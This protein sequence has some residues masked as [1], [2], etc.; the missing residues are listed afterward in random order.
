MVRLRWWMHDPHNLNNQDDQL[1]NLMGHMVEQVPTHLSLPRGGTASL[2]LPQQALQSTP[3]HASLSASHYV[4][5]SPNNISSVRQTDPVAA[6][7]T[8]LATQVQAASR[9][10]KLPPLDDATEGSG[11]ATESSERGIVSSNKNS[12]SSGSSL[13]NTQETN[14]LEFQHYAL[15]QSLGGNYAA[16]ISEP[17]RILDIGAGTGRW[18][19]EMATVFPRASVIGLDT[20][21]PPLASRPQNFIA[22]RGNVEENLP[23]ADGSFD[24]VHQRLVFSRMAVRRLH[25]GVAELVRVTAPGGWV[26]LVEVDVNICNGGMAN[27][28]IVTWATEVCRA[29]GIDPHMGTRV[30]D[31][32]RM[33]KL[34]NLD[35]RSIELP[36]GRWGG[37][38]GRLMAADMLAQ[39]QGMK[40]RICMQRRVKERE[41]EQVIWQMQQ[42]WEQKH[43]TM[44]F[45]V[46]YGQRDGQHTRR[47]KQA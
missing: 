7:A 38:I 12:V 2:A 1:E 13:W 16:P 8:T 36:I 29:S 40:E 47:A 34:Q 9:T 21:L 32:L 18:C 4:R 31:F 41:Y 22:M 10:A 37:R 17:R 28:K 23:F 20:M 19:I 46:A 42:E 24:F 6:S 26:E 43:C 33:M 25:A 39:C 45:Y 35:V 11:I 30:G 15:R 27:K 14:R 5:I 3:M 44:V